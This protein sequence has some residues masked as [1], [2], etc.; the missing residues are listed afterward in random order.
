MTW[1]D[2]PLPEDELIHAA[3]PTRTERHDL[4]MEASRLVGAKRSKFALIALVNWL[5]AQR[6]E[7]RQLVRDRVNA[8]TDFSRACPAEFAAVERWKQ[9]PKS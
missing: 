7:A 3:F 6:E 9:E 4:Y 1:D 5:L 8:Q 2:A